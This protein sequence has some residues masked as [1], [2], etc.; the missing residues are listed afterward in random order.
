M[1]TQ[2]RPQDRS[3]PPPALVEWEAPTDTL[4]GDARYIGYVGVTEH[5]L[6]V[7]ELIRGSE[8]WP[9][10]FRIHLSGKH[11]YAAKQSMSA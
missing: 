3:R 2:V 10:K 11:Q 7:E 9:E 4:L 6:R 5:S 8:I 1:R